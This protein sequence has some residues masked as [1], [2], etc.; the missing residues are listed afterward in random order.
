MIGPGLVVSIFRPAADVGI[1]RKI[2][3]SGYTVANDLVAS[4]P[5][6]RLSHARRH[7]GLD[8]S[9]PLSRTGT[10]YDLVVHEAVDT[11]GLLLN[12]AA[13]YRS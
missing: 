3:V 6:G 12:G 8:V 7:I 10:T 2:R 4:L 11:R 13:T 5:T 1:R 9:E